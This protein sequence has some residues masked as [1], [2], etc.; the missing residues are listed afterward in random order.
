MSKLN[1][2]QIDEKR[3]FIIKKV[4]KMKKVIVVTGGSS[5]I[6]K[7]LIKNLDKRNFFIINLSRKNFDKIKK[8]PKYNS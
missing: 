8:L 6:G 3:Y 4:F 7:F 1:S 5:G 2:L